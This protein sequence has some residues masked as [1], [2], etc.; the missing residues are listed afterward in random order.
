MNVSLFHDY[1]WPLML[2]LVNILW[3]TQAALESMHGVPSDRKQKKKRFD[4]K[5]FCSSAPRTALQIFFSTLIH[6]SADDIF[7]LWSNFRRNKAYFVAKNSMKLY[8][9]VEHLVL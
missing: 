8:H 1:K 9:T 4:S 3:A 6:S 7:E 5:A 2:I